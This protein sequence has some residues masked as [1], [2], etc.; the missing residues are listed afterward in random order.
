MRDNA[1][2]TMQADSLST[3]KRAA[4]VYIGSDEANTFMRKENC[5]MRINVRSMSVHGR[6]LI[7]G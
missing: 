2:G 1:N 3:A 7:H 4:N 6:R 5:V